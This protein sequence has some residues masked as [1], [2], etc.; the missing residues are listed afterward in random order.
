MR[1]KDVLLSIDSFKV[2]SVYLTTKIIQYLPIKKLVLNISPKGSPTTVLS[3]KNNCRVHCRF[4]RC[5]TSNDTMT[6]Q[7]TDNKARR[8]K[9]LSIIMS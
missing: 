8:P 9:F 5:L 3:K 7:N 1:E 6:E 4:K 2:E